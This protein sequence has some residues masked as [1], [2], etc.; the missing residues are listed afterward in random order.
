[1]KKIFTFGKKKREPPPS[2]SAA[3][4]CPAGAYELRPKEL[5]KLHRAAAAG[6]LVQVRQAL[7]KYRIDGRDKEQR[8]ALHLACANGHADVVTF[9]VENNCK[10]NLPDTDNRSPLM[11][12]VQCQQEKCATVLLEHGAD[13]NLADA[14]GNTALHMAAVAPNTS[15][16]RMLIEHSAHI[17]AKNK[18]GCTPL[19]LAVSE[20]HEEMVELLLKK[21]ADVH[22]RDKGERTPLMTAAAGGELKLIKLLLCYGADLSHK[23]TNGW[24]AEDYAIIHGHSSLSKQLVEGENTGEASARDS[25]DIAVPMTPDKSSATG[26]TLGAPA[27]DRGRIFNC[28]MQPSPKQTSRKGESRKAIDDISEG[29]S[30]RSSE[31]ED[32]SDSW[33]TSDEEELDFTPKKPQKP[34]LAVLMNVSQK[35]RNSIPVMD[36]EDAEEEQ[37]KQVDNKFHEALKQGSENLCLN[38]CEENPRAAFTSSTKEEKSKQEKEDTGEELLTAVLMGVENSV[39]SNTRQVQDAAHVRSALPA[40]GAEKEQ[41]SESPWDSESDSESLRKVSPGVLL[42]A[43]DEHGACLLNNSGEH[44]N[45]FSEKHSNLQLKA[46]AAVLEM[47]EASS[48][49]ERRKSDLLEELILEDVDDIEGIFMFITKMCSDSVFHAPSSSEEEIVKDAIESC[50]DQVKCIL[51]TTNLVERTA[52]VKQTDRAE[53]S[54]QEALAKNKESHSADK[55]LNLKS[56]EER[57]ERMWVENEKRELKAIFKKVT[58]ELKQLFGEIDE[59]EKS[60]SLA[61]E[62]AE[63]DFK[64]ELENFCVSSWVT[65]SS[66]KLESKGEFGDT[67]LN[68]DLEEP[69]LEI[70]IS[71]CAVLPDHSNLN[72][73]MDNIWSADEEDCAKCT[74]NTEVPLAKGEEMEE[75]ENGI[76][77]NVEG[78]P[79]YSLRHCLE[80]NILDGI[81]NI[82]PKI[83]RISTNDESTLGL[84]RERKFDKDV[85]LSDSV[86]RDCLSE[87]KEMGGMEIKN[88]FPHAQ[89]PS[90][91]LKRNLDEEL[92]QDVE[93]FKSKVGM[94]QMVF[95][96]LEKEKVQL[97]KEVEKEERKQ[98]HFKMQTMEKQDLDKFSTPAGDITSQPVKEKLALR[99]NEEKT[100]SERTIE[101][102]MHT[103]NS[104][105][106]ERSKLTEMPLKSKSV[107]NAKRKKKKKKKRQSSK[108]KA[109]QKIQGLMDDSTVSETSQD[110]ERRATRTG[111]KKKKVSTQMAVTDDL[112][113]TQSSDTT[114]WDAEWTTSNCKKAMLLLE[115]LSAVYAGSAVPLKIQS[116]LLEYEQMISREKNHHTAL[117]R[118]AWKLENEKEELQLIAEETKD[119]KSMLAHQEV[120]FKSDIQSLKFSLKQEEERRLKAEMQN[121]TMKEQLRKKE[122]Q[123]YRET[124]KKQQLELHARNLET[125]LIS[126]RKLLKQTEEERDEIQMQL[127][128][129]KSARALQEG[130]LNSHLQRQ[131]DLEVQSRKTMEKNSEES[132][133]SE[134]EKDLLYKNQLLQEEIAMLRLE[135]DQVKLRHQEDEGKY[136]VDIETLKEKNEDL[137]KELKLNEE[138]LTQ[139]VLQYSGQLNFL[140]TE[141]AVLTSKLE[142]TKEIK[143]RLEIEIESFRSRLNA[144]LQD[145]ERHQSLKSDVER[146]FQRERE[147][148]LRLQDKLHHELCDMREANKGLTQQLSKM[149]SKASS[150]EN[151]LHRLK[152]TLQEKTLLLEL[153]QKELNQ[154][155]CQAKES[156]HAWQL[157]KDQVSK[158]MIKQE[159][160]QERLAQFQSENIL[161]HQQ[162]EDLQN[163]GIMKEKAVNDV[164]DRFNDIFNK[165]RADTEKQV[166]LMEERNKELNTKCTDLREQVFKHETDKVERECTV[167]QLQQ[168][169]AEAL[170]K[171]SMSEASLEVTTRY[172]SDLEEDK[173]RLQKELD[174][175]KTKLQESEEQRIQSEHCVHDLKAVL[176]NQEREISASS[177]KLQDLLLANSGTNIT[178]KQL[179]EHV[180]RLE[181][182]NAR[183][184]A[185]SKQ[186][187]NRIEALQKD[188]HASASCES[189]RKKVEKL[190]ESKQPV[191]ARLDQ[192][193]RRNI[194]LQKEC[195]RCKKLL[196]RA[197]KKLRM[198]ESRERESRHN[199]QEQMKQRYSEMVN[200][201]DRLRTKV[202]ELSQKLELESKKCIHLEAQNQ[203]LKEELH[204]LHES[205]EKLEKNKR[206]LKEEVAKLRHHLETNT[207]NHIQIEQYKKEIDERAAQ[208]IRQ[209]LQEVNVFLQ[210]QAASQDHL[211][212]IRASHH[213]SLTNQLKH[214]IQSLEYELDRIKNTQQDNVF[215][216]ESTKAEAERYKERYLEEMKARKCLANKLERANEKLSDANT[217]LLQERQRSKS[218]IASSFVGGGLPTS[219][220]LYSAELGHLDNH[221]AL[222]RSLGLG[223]SFLGTAGNVLSQ[224]KVEAYMAKIRKE[225]DEKITKELEQ[226]TADL[227]TRSPR[228]SPMVSINGSSKNLSVDQ[229]P[230]CRAIQEYRD[231]LTKNYLI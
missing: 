60:T 72:A 115:Q 4:P 84:I 183:L 6:V 226:A 174:R 47:N 168:E 220:V 53:I 118:K 126:L 15:L 30:I 19:I 36:D 140:R 3:S 114:T 138:A 11:K 24:T 198:Y 208:E 104:S 79:E 98:K 211:E 147:E 192:E 100:E 86:S 185:T 85:I 33:H 200:E 22:A 191:E 182:E 51:E 10:L 225:L 142:Q 50:G 81:S 37:C 105:S 218:L 171:Q 176:D 165:L 106:E 46:S 55:Q 130:I 148:W 137:K 132:D 124:E 108:K 78:S 197:V 139:T 58:A 170:K 12:A 57:Y 71:N 196:N 70:V 82:P 116:I 14:S 13:P 157:E 172:R 156:D 190:V 210:A 74:D 91:M 166:Y 178:I 222:N 111:S 228:G 110:E 64:E 194:E 39:C 65:E 97:Q 1:M 215:Q 7:K 52:H 125:E 227:G 203:D 167:R 61:A 153:T 88:L 103:E 40:V 122:D 67:K 187:T 181:I 21:G 205:H 63:D 38:R 8:T 214:R 141:S 161:L 223:G 80:T 43:A 119:L 20:H 99:K 62:V 209:K 120:E 92:K 18:E 206:Q 163:K 5:S 175:M 149:E 26:F 231:V 158:F 2:C 186:Q 107:L 184:E 90:G 101:E 150:L 75:N 164:Q 151:E 173:L 27:M 204:T 217:K 131:K 9:L 169:L 133:T 117:Q 155:Q 23:D 193:M 219:P 93:R 134:R 29:G 121:E 45:G 179:E 152:Q 94:L 76:S 83:R 189:E 34:N 59:S 28:G 66:N 123:Y 224:S 48:K 96:A 73:N 95:L 229:D 68:A 146:T 87:L 199:F 180:Q 143:D 213:A 69:K 162:L 188:L 128:Q 56:W 202:T 41:E 129:E 25:Q 109:K 221:L 216:Q 145:L 127:T 35:F 89:Q 113:L 17:D 54:P 154:A 49:K 42:P 230:H 102:E 32:D 195:H 159:S 77:R 136:V 212:Q 135:F 112:D 177:Q 144:A 201:V 16:A 160:M 207:V 31:K 44:N